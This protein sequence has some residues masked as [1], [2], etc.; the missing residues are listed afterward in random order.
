M[1]AKKKPNT[2][3]NKAADE[4]M[5]LAKRG[6][7]EQNYFFTTTFERYQTQLAILDRLKKEIAES[8]L[9]ISREYTR[10]LKNSVC[11]PAITEYNKT[12]QAANTTVI[13]LMKIISVFAKSSLSA[14]AAST[15]E[16]SEEL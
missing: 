1:A 4:L 12:S 13:T 11:N 6:G 3:M 2:D 7:V 5:K 9:K 16:E 10:G 14:N 15:I 8:D